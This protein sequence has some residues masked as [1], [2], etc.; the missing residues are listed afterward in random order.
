M[1]GIE[2]AGGALVFLLFLIVYTL[3]VAYGLYS[4]S[5]SA[6]SSR[7]YAKVYASSPGARRTYREHEVTSWS[8]GTR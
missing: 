5:G 4:R 7:P 1:L 6:I 2:L 8:R 3:A